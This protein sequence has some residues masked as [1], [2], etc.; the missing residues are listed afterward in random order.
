MVLWWIGNILLIA[1][2]LPVVIILLN[3]L[4][5]PAKEIEAYANDILDH[6]VK[7]TGAL[8]AVPKLYQTADLVGT[9]RRNVERYGRTL[10][11][12]L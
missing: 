11:R 3:K 9:A 2:I 10:E 12:V 4:L 5:R 6:G 1:V 8:D 7:L